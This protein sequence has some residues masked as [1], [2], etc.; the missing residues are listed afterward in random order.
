M[1]WTWRR[2]VWTRIFFNFCQF[3]AILLVINFQKYKNFGYPNTSL[4]LVRTKH[5]AKKNCRFSWPAEEIYQKLDDVLKYFLQCHVQ[6]SVYH[7]ISVES[8][9]LFRKMGNMHTHT[10]QR[11]SS[12]KIFRLNWWIVVDQIPNAIQSAK[13][14]WVFVT[15]YYWLFTD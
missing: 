2:Q 7:C 13:Y 11:P 14:Y 6:L 10:G 5:S 15:K 1:G 8:S 4:A 12:T 9:L 3:F